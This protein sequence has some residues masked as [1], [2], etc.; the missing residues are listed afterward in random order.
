MQKKSQLNILHVITTLEPEGAQLLLLNALKF[1]DQSKYKIY[2]AY[3]YRSGLALK[4]IKLPEEVTIIDLSKKS[5]FN[6]FSLFKLIHI[7][8]NNKID[9]VHTHL[10]HAG[11]LGKIAAKICGV[12]NVI[13]TRHYGYQIKENSLLFRFEDMLTKY[14]STVIAISTSVKDYLLSKKIVPESKITI[15]KNGIDLDL[16][17][18]GRKNKKN[19][20]N[21]CMKIGSIGR[22]HPIKGYDYLLETFKIVNDKNPLL[23]LEIVGDGKIKPDLLKKAKRLNLLKNVTFLGSLPPSNVISIL[24]DWDLFILPSLWEGFGIV[25]LE[26]MAM[27]L[28]VI[29]TKIGGIKEIVKDGETGILVNPKNP[30]KMANAILLL[31]NDETK[32]LT[33]GKAGQKR[34]L[35]NFS[36]YEKTKQLEKIYDSLFK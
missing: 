12:K 2:V 16:F 32:R 11:I 21:H 23:K 18:S 4:Y 7:I 22:L 10:V 1:F 14:S 6:I 5:K 27:Q 33:M 30:K 20:H 24:N 15:I 31:L 36:L 9:L 34:I 28:A 3:L 8:K 35:E 13:T 29:A 25:I 17:K 26:A 19:K